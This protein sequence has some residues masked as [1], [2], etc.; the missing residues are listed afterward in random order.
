M[1]RLEGMRGIKPKLKVVMICIVGM[2]G[3]GPEL[4]EDVNCPKGNQ[5]RKVDPV[6]LANCFGPAER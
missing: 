5:G 1:I 6:T 4:K 3:I 2:R